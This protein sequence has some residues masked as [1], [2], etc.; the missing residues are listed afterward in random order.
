MSL[1]TQNNALSP[2]A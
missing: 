1:T 2:A